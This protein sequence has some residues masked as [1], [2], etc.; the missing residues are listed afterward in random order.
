MYHRVKWT[1]WILLGFLAFSYALGTAGRGEVPRIAKE[2]LKARM[3][4]PDLMILDV[5]SARDWKKSD[6]K[7]K[8]AI[9]ENPKKDAKSWAKKY[10]KDKTLVLYCA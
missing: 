8:G 9:R 2:E 3:S 5:R 10:G 4:D 6:L 1:F 7:I